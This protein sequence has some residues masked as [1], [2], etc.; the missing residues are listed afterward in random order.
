[1]WDYWHVPGQY[2]LLRT[3]AESFFPEPLYRDLEAQLLDHAMS[4]GCRALTP[5]WLSYYV[6]GCRQELH[7]DSPHGPW[8]FVLSL[9]DWE[10]RRFSGG[11][12]QLLQPH[13]LDY[14]SGFEGYGQEVGSL[15]Q[16]IEPR[17]NRLTLF[18][19]RVPH[20]VVP[21]HGMCTQRY[22]Y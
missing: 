6:E 1:M 20:G 9:T 12:T 4:L 2:T 11:Q 13:V 14:W 10:A 8:A 19:P 5:V 3:P 15:V 7:T 22:I 21:V 18:D 16:T 17:F